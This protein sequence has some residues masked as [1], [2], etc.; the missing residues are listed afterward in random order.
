MEAYPAH[1]EAGPR[2]QMQH[3]RLI[4]TARII[5]FVYHRAS[6]F[7]YLILTADWA[8]RLWRPAGNA[9]W[10]ADRRF[11][12]DRTIPADFVQKYLPAWQWLL[13]ED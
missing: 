12:P 11:H 7:R 9:E 4:E 1:H 13:S 10:A 6:F 3:H 8:A 2:G 5:S